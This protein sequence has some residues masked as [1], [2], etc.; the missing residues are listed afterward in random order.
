V[1]CAGLDVEAVVLGGRL[2][3]ILATRLAAAANLSQSELDAVARR[4]MAHPA[5]VIVPAAISSRASV[6][7]AAALSM[8]FLRSGEKP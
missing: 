5:P 8:P 4:G 7:G 2:P 6:I 1:I 3:P